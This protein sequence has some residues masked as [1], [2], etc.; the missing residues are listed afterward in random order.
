M[1]GIIFIDQRK[2]RDKK[3]EQIEQV[4]VTHDPI[5]LIKIGASADEYSS[6]AKM[7]YER[8]AKHFALEKIH[9]IIYDIFINQFSG[10]SC[11]ETNQGMLEYTGEICPSLLKAEPIIGKFEKYLP[12]AKEIKNILAVAS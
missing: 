2:M 7:I 9:I 4:L 11:F 6:E 3:L 5:G 12:I 10:G 1:I 8:T